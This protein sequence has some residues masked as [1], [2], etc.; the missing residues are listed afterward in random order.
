MDKGFSLSNIKKPKTKMYDLSVS[1]I[2]Y[3]KPKQICRMST[4]ACLEGEK[5]RRNI[6]WSRVVSQSLAF[7]RAARKRIKPWKL[8]QS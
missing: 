5:R 3:Y 8:P 7:D 4:E 2:S 1:F 6:F